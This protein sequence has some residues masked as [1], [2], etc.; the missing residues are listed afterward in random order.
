MSNDSTMQCFSRRKVFSL[1]G[2]A[3]TVCLAIPATM[4]TA[5]DAEAQT[6][7]M[8]RRQDRRVGRRERRDDRRQARHNR[9]DERRGTTT[10]SSST[11]GS[12]AAPK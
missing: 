5:A 10:G 4:L 12:T 9:R 6:T 2:I 3:A 7:G 11:T 1:V 8:D